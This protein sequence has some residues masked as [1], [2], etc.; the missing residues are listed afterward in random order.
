MVDDP[1]GTYLE[2]ING[3][4]GAKAK[5][6]IVTCTGGHQIELFEY[7]HPQNR[8]KYIPRPCDTGASH[9]AFMVD[10]FDT[11]LVQF[12]EYGFRPVNK[13]PDAVAPSGGVQRT[14]YL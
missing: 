4:P 1:G 13:A 11:A 14:A 2:D 5:I 10:D 8:K 6:A 12:D 7:L 3:C 9:M